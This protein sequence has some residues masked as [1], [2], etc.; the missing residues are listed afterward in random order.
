MAAGSFS[1][2]RVMSLPS[3]SLIFWP[4]AGSNRY[5]RSFNRK[6]EPELRPAEAMRPMVSSSLSSTLFRKVK[7]AM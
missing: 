1:T 7:L 5:T 3:S 2:Y 4:V 6:A